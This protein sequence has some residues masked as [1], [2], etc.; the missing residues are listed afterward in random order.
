MPVPLTVPGVID[1]FIQARHVWPRSV[2][3]IRHFGLHTPEGPEMPTYA[4]NLGRYFATT[5]RVAS[6]HFGCDNVLTVRYARDDQ[7]CA[8]ARGIN[9]SGIH[10]EIAGVA[11]QTAAQWADEFSTAALKRAANVFKLYGPGT[12]ANIPAVILSA[13]EL[14]AGRAGIVKH[15]TAWAVFGGDF[16]SDP[17]ANFPDDLFLALCRGEEDTED[18]SLTVRNLRT[19]HEAFR[20]GEAWAIRF[21][22]QVLSLPAL[23]AYKGPI[24]GQRTPALNEAISRAKAILPG[25]TG[26]GPAMGADLWRELVR[27]AGAFPAETAIVEVP[28]DCSKVETELATARGELASALTKIR[29]AK[30]A[31]A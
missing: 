1:E 19:G 29:A 17:G 12:D 27:V 2:T 22:Q 10:I 20:T 30:G 31:L 5:D 28:G 21:V 24:D 11:A 3:S 4:R 14:R 15:S 18:M 26:T 6:T 9:T 23:D 8:S 16:R 7:T 25:A 13:D